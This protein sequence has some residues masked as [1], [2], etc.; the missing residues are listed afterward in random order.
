MN[1][2]EVILENLIDVSELL[3]IHLYKSQKSKITKTNHSQL[4][5]SA[6]IGCMQHL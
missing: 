6:V 4:F 2:N 5:W 3:E 1:E